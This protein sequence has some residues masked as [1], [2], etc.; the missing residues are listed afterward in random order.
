L[1]PQAQNAYESLQSQYANSSW[2]VTFLDVLDSIQTLLN[3]E[4]E[5]VRAGRDWRVSVAELEFLMGGSWPEPED[6]ESAHPM[7]VSKNE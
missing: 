7:S 4:L 6:T 1:I 5:H 2:D 3:F